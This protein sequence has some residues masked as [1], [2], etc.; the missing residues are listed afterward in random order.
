MLVFFLSLLGDFKAVYFSVSRSLPATKGYLLLG[1][2]RAS[3]GQSSR[4][5]LLLFLRPWNQTKVY[6][7]LANGALKVLLC[8]QVTLPPFHREWWSL[9]PPDLLQYADLWKSCDSGVGCLS[10]LHQ[11]AVGSLPLCRYLRRL[12]VSPA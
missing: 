5:G 4:Q 1:L 2:S 12:C 7:K 11:L 3:N 6:H 10:I 8:G 9:V